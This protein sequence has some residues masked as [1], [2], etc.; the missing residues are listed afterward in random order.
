[1]LRGHLVAASIVAVAVASVGAVFAFARPTYHPYVIPGSINHD[2]PYT[3]VSYTAAD[4][5]R[6][7]AAEG[8]HLTPRSHS[9]TITTLGN[10]RDILVVDAFGDPEKV[11][12]S[13]FYDFTLVNGRYA[14]FP[15]DCGSGSPSAERWQGNVRVIVS[16]TATGSSSR[17]WL[18]CAERALARL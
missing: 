13:G 8:I 18:L 4:A 12:Q 16:C 2:L 10:Q 5:R 9:P 14:H 17:L 1:M 6:V 15:R 7:F 11:K 3:V